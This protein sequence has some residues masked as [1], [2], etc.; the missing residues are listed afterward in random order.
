MMLIF[1]DPPVLGFERSAQLVGPC[2]HRSHL[3]S[4][5]WG[6]LDVGTV[7]QAHL[8]NRENCPLPLALLPRSLLCLLLSLLEK[9]MFC[10]FTVANESRLRK[11]TLPILKAEV[12]EF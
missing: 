11:G 8:G 5:F 7:C 1:R 12:L 4:W 9:N 6:A 2:V 10:E 3:Q